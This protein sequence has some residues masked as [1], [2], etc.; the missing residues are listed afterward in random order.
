ML[1][2]DAPKASADDAVLLSD[3][4]DAGEDAASRVSPNVPI[5]V[6]G[7][8]F[9]AV[10]IYLIVDRHHVMGAAQVVL[11]FMLVNPWL[12]FVG[13]VTLYTTNSVLCLPVFPL[14]LGTCLGLV[15][16]PWR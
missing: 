4:D 3:D 8:L 5:A 2:L 15:A 14:I 10:C 13:F 1:A 7:A 12:G 16:A 6:L 11:D 9:A